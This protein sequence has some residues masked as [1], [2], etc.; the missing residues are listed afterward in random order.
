MASSFLLHPLCHPDAA[1]GQVDFAV[2]LLY[3]LVPCSMSRFEMRTTE[4]FVTPS[5][6]AMLRELMSKMGAAYLVD[7]EQ[8][9]Q[10]RCGQLHTGHSPFYAPGPARCYH[11]LTLF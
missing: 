2:V 8:I 11:K 9:A 1:V 5:F 7:G 3:D 10:M 6:S 4:G